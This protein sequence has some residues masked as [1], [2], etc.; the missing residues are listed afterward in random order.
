MCVSTRQSVARK[1]VGIESPMSQFC[2]YSPQDKPQLEQLA[3]LE[4]LSYIGSFLRYVRK[5]SSW[6][7]YS[8]PEL[9]LSED[10]FPSWRLPCR[11]KSKTKLL[12]WAVCVFEEETFASQELH[13]FGETRPW[14]VALLAISLTLSLMPVFGCDYF[15][16]FSFGEVSKMV[17]SYV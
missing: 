3:A 10:C 7:V 17:I 14:A 1:P 16:V 2:K 11:W 13:P 12:V 8:L 5:R 4:K 9:G 6:K 15:R